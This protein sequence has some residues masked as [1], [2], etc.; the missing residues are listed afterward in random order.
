MRRGTP[1]SG[2]YAGAPVRY[3]PALL[4][5][6]LLVGVGCR[7][8]GPGVSRGPQGA[9]APGGHAGLAPDVAAAEQDLRDLRADRAVARLEAAGGIAVDAPERSW[10]LI[11]LYLGRCDTARARA[12]T[13]ALPDGP[14]ARVLR[15]RA[16]RDPARRRTLLRG[17]AVGAA[18]PWADLELA[19]A[20][21]D[22]GDR[23]EAVSAPAMRACTR[24]SAF[25]RREARLL[26]SGTALE[27]DRAEEAAAHA[28]AA[29]REDPSDP[30]PP[31]LEGVALGRMGRKSEA[32][33]LAARALSLAPRSGR[34]ARRLADVLREG[35]SPEVEARLRAELA[36]EIA[37]PDAGPELLALQGVLA[38]RAGDYPTA[39][40]RYERA[41]A[42]GADPVP[43]DRH[44]RR[45]LW[46]DGRRS[47]ALRLLRGAVPPEAFAD[48][49]N[50]RRPAWEALTRAANGVADGPT[51]AAGDAALAALG[52]ALVGVGASPDAEV[53]LAGARGPL[54][55]AVHRRA[56]AITAFVEALHE[57]VEAGYRAK[58]SGNDPP[59]L[60][61][62]R[63]RMRELAG[64]HLEPADLP[65]FE[66][67]TAGLRSVPLLGEWLDHGASTTSPTVA[68]FRRHGSYL[69][70]GQRAG[71][72]PEA[73]L[74][75]LASLRAGAEVR[76]QGRS[77]RHDV[78]IGFD[79]SIRSRLDQQ[80]GALSGAALPDGLWLD[81]DASRRENHA[82][83]VQLGSLDAD[84]RARVEH[85]GREAPWPDGPEGPFALD[86][87]AGVVTRLGL[88][89]AQRRKDPWGAFDVL[90]AH[91]SGHVL[92]LRR[93]LPIVKGLPATLALVAGSGFD[94]E[95][96]EARL[97][98]RAQL[99][100]VSDAPDPDL[101]LIDLI[102]PLPLFDRAPEVHDRGYRDAAAA[103]VRWVHRHAARFPAID[104]TRKV[105]P[106]LDRLAPEEIRAAARGVL[107]EGWN[108]VA[109]SGARVRTW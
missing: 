96:V 36:R 66:V 100:A 79:R 107:A 103:I 82:L 89:Y 85:A 23:P 32:A 80:G 51:D 73:I 33:A 101:A 74:L 50:L 48:P 44:L 35:P 92:D 8:S 78:A 20:M 11:G 62:L 63:R 42:A 87:T 76:T 27:D 22:E 54:A 30:R 13:A 58:A 52:E 49:S 28:R 39:R 70:M 43:V 18:A 21:A 102:R 69:M 83:R 59:P 90:R 17:A 60:G 95:A 55:V 71:E 94:I 108:P 1:G 25:V 5:V 104:P 46:R 53:A 7:A 37:R 68:W 10:L 97:E 29:A 88:R 81:A 47:D 98:G 84:L 26:L 65:A 6:A 19:S 109:P 75:S 105:L 4:L 15:S 86:D 9:A 34:A 56:A 67:G 72:A 64:K 40:A 45:L 57:Q 61:D 77:L 14:M 106:Q 31:A 16:A 93:H 2:R 91:E 3:R 41:L 38:E 99:A 24:G 12:L